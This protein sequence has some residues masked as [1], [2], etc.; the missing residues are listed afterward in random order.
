MPAPALKFFTLEYLFTAYA[1]HTHVYADGSVTE[2]SSAI[3]VWIPSVQCTIRKKLSHKTSS[4]AT[5][6]AAVRAALHFIGAHQARRWVIFLDSRGALQALRRLSNHCSQLV[7]EI[8]EIHTAVVH[9]GHYIV[10]QWLPGHSGIEGNII[11]DAAASAGHSLRNTT[12]LPFSREDGCALIYRTGWREQMLKWQH[13]RSGYPPLHGIDP[14]C[15][16]RVPPDLSKASEGVLH[17][18]RLN[19]A[20]TRSFKFKIGWEDSPLCPTCAVRETT[21][22]LLCI[23]PRFSAARVTAASCLSRVRRGA[24]LQLCHFLGPWDNNNDSYL[25]TKIL[26]RFLRDSGLDKTL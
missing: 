16:F 14:F 2:E 19:V 6:L 18:L 5:E 12:Q 24:S 3:G 23:C 4:T 20:Y 17:R 26:L 22:H 1:S 13:P 15:K 9:A 21:E 7:C 8:S 10:L 25:G 11:S